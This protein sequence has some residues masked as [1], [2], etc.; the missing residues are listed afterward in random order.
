MDD[1][2]LSPAR[3]KGLTM[4][5][6][7]ILHHGA[8][9]GVTGPCHQLRIDAQHSLLIDIEALVLVCEGRK[10]LSFVNLLTVDSNQP[11]LSIVIAAGGMCVSM[12]STISSSYSMIRS[13]AYCL[14]VA[15]LKAQRSTPFRSMVQLMAM[16]Y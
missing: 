9:A 4:I 5:Y 15:K 13:L 3:V 2:T 11:H 12:S 8:I 10:P 16:C 14:W 1:V 7:H 6:P